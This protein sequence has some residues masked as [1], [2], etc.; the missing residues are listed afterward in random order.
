M[1]PKV[2]GKYFWT[3]IHLV[4][5]GY[6]DSPSDMDAQNYKQFYIN[7]WKVLPCYSCSENYKKHL[8]ELPI[9]SFLKDNVSLFEWTVKLHNIVNKELGKRVVTLEEAKE[10][11]MRLAKGNEDTV[12]VSIDSNWD[13]LIRHG[14][15]IVLLLLVATGVYYGVRS[16]MKRK[17]LKP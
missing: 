15:N 10:R 7:F 2:W 12:F 1:E 5:L 17:V 8:Q 3:T 4:A 13:K 9:D 16:V 6:P 14:V 11:Y